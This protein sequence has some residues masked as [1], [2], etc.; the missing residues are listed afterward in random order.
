MLTTVAATT[1]TDASVSSATLPIRKLMFRKQD[2]AIREEAF[3]NKEGSEVMYP[4]D[5]IVKGT[6]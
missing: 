2:T 5:T 3:E 4:V 6:A 1:S